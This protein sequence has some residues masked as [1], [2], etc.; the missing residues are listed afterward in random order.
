MTDTAAANKEY[1][2]ELKARYQK[3][4]DAGMSD[5]EL[6]CLMLSYA[7]VTPVLRETA[8]AIE[9]HFGT[10]RYAYHAKYSELVR[11]E[12][13]TRHAAV[14]LLIIGKLVS[15]SSRTPSVGKR[16]TEY[17][18]MFVGV[19]RYSLE[20]ELWAAA[21][22]DTGVVI[23]LERI[24]KGE[25]AQVSVNVSKL[26]KFAAYCKT[27][28]LIIAHSHPGAIEPIASKADKYAMAYIGA[29]LDEIGIELIGQVIVAGKNAKL[30]RYE[31]QKL[32]QK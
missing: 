31:R 23:A 9:K 8:D 3:S 11:I 6:L 22:S 7:N 18:E 24:A 4:G 30:I 19:M 21:L 16:V 15:M 10:V 14:L 17:E 12:G 13:M 1:A 5:K 26:V 25:D 20:E 27:H 2:K 29:T 28:K 32:K